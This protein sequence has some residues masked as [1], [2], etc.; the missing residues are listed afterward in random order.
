MLS[1][2]LHKTK[3]RAKSR[4]ARKSP[5]GA[6]SK[7]V[8]PNYKARMDGGKFGCYTKT[9]RTNKPGKKA[10]RGYCRKIAKG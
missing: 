6:R 5:K 4:K 2:I 9:V 10:L 8:T 1:A 7:K 3:K